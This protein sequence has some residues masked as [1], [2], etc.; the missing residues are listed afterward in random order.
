MRHTLSMGERVPLGQ[1][2]DERPRSGGLDELGHEGDHGGHQAD[3]S[4]RQ[5]DLS[6]AHSHPMDE[7]KP[8]TH[9]CERAR[10]N[11]LEGGFG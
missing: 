7:K 8:A 11:R 10:K 9:R 2:F 1:F 4:G 5:L 6:F 3:D